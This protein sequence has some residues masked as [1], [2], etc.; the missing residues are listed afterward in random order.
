MARCRGQQI[1]VSRQPIP[2]NPRTFECRLKQAASKTLPLFGDEAFVE[3]ALP[4]AR[5]E[6]AAQGITP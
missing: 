5:F 6:R 4:L 2:R 1:Q 3:E